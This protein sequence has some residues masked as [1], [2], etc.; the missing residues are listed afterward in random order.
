MDAPGR[1]SVGRVSSSSM[2]RL[3]FFWIALIQSDTDMK[4]VVH[5][6]LVRLINLVW[7]IAVVR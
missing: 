3:D 6:L 5:W 2:V 7:G 1:F 4:N